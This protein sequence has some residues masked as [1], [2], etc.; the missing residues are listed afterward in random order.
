[1]RGLHLG[2]LIFVLIMAQSIAA[3]CT[4]SAFKPDGR[5]KSS[6]SNDEWTKL[7]LDPTDDADEIQQLQECQ[8]L[9]TGTTTNS[10]HP[11]PSWLAIE[12]ELVIPLRLLNHGSEIT[13]SMKRLVAFLAENSMFRTTESSADQLVI[14]T[15]Y[16]KRKTASGELAFRIRQPSTQFLFS[17]IIGV[18]PPDSEHF[19]TLTASD[20]TFHTSKRTST[21]DRARQLARLIALLDNQIFVS[22]MAQCAGYDRSQTYHQDFESKIGQA[23]K[24]IQENLITIESVSTETSDTPHTT[25]LQVLEWIPPQTKRLESDE[26]LQMDSILG[27]YHSNASANKNLSDQPFTVQ[28]SRIDLTALH[29]VIWTQALSAKIDNQQRSRRT[30]AFD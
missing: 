17:G 22:H 1:M 13:S 29:I 26:D 28:R 5:V 11:R 6:T 15:A 20:I 16:L 24:L 9:Q 10:G 23:K 14:R 2:H 18:S 7:L 19:I 27:G 4:P 8:N 30:K 25:L 12:E 3:G 21:D